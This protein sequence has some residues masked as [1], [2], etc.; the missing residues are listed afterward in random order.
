[1][2]AEGIDAGGEPAAV[3]VDVAGDIRGHRAGQQVGDCCWCPIGAQSINGGRCSP[4]GVIEQPGGEV[5]IAGTGPA[6]IGAEA[7]IACGVVAVVSG[8]AAQACI[9]GEQPDAAAQVVVDHFRAP[10]QLIGSGEEATCRVVLISDRCT[11]IP[12][13]SPQRIGLAGQP[14]EGIKLLPASPA[15]RVCGGDEIAGGFV[16][17]RRHRR[18]GCGRCPWSPYLQDPIHRVIGRE[19]SSTQRISRTDTVTCRV[20]CRARNTA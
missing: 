17:E 18:G 20:V 9:R 15:Q 10:A 1:M 13:E 4:Q 8:G 3:V 7:Q 2:P 14:P 12:S 11:W 5:R 6:R 19:G 16:H